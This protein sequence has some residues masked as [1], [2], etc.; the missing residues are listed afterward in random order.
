MG[1]RKFAFYGGLF[2]ILMGLLAFMPGLSWNSHLLPA[3]FVNESYGMFLGYFPMNILNKAAL[4]VFGVAGVAVSYSS[5]VQPSVF[6]ARIVFIVMGLLAILGMFPE[7]NSL[8]GYW[9]LFSGEILAHGVLALFGGYFGYV[10]NM[11][12]RKEVDARV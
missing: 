12:V 3:L 6:F 1:N 5:N 9:P 7:T 8:Y 2:M 10:V 11:R 4:I